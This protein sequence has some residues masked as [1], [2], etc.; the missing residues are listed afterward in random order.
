[1][2]TIIVVGAG[3]VGLVTGACFA[4]K[5]NR[6]IIVE[7]N[8]NRIDALLKGQVPFFEPGLDEIVING[9]K[10][11]KLVFVE[12]IEQAFGYNA[13]VIFSCV[14]TPSLP[15][16]SADLSYVWSVAKEIGQH[17]KEYT[18]IIN[19]S[20][21]PVGVGKAVKQI[22]QEQLNKRNVSIEFDVASNP[23]FLKE[24]DAL[25]DFLQPDRVVVGVSSCKAEQILFDL[26]KPF[27]HNENQFLSMNVESAELTKYASNAM[28]ATRIS[29][30]N[31]MALL[32]DKV[33]ADILQVK[34]GMARDTRIGA[35]FLNA[36][37]GFGGSCFPKDI[38]ALIHMGIQH[39]QPMTLLQEVDIVNDRQRNWFMNQIIQHY[40]NNL[41]G[42]KI[43]I[44]GLAF[45]PETD[46]IRC[47]PSLDVIATLLDKGAEIIAYD[48]VAADNVKS[49]FGSSIK[50]ASTAQQVLENCNALAILTEWKEFLM[51]K[52]EDFSRIKDGVIFDGRNCFNPY[53][54]QLAGIMYFC[55]GR[56]SISKSLETGQ[57]HATAKEHVNIL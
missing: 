17:M 47:A 54:M 10:T 7:N 9:I 51:Y 22:I 37:I 50:F 6:V 11:E 2:K 45:K 30:M 48:P 3:Y 5:E 44:W 23:E 12:H 18:V 29:F 25:N 20:T 53:Q 4:L 16:G 55:V 21:V 39:E 15:D 52:P 35:A 8:K 49:I 26:Y 57:V 27:L 14:G 36:G 32:A 31:Q 40:S 46:D 41:R 43:G 28:L 38:K 42:K 1:M 24:G 19:K 34:Q 13:E 33:G 56:N